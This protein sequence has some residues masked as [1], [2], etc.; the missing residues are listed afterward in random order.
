MNTQ[1]NISQAIL[2][3]VDNVESEVTKHVVPHITKERTRCLF[4]NVTYGA[5]NLVIDGKTWNIVDSA[6]RK[7]V[8][9]TTGNATNASTC[10]ATNDSFSKNSTGDF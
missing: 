5:T 8:H 6:I 10:D 7:I 1:Y 9:E 3:A 2:S 4:S